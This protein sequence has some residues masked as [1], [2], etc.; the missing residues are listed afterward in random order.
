MEQK[1]ESKLGFKDH[2]IKFYFKNKVKIYL[3][4]LIFISGILTKIF[5]A[6]Y[7]EEKNIAVSEKYVQAEL[8]LSSNKKDDA[9]KI[10]EEI[11]RSKNKFYSI[12]ALNTILEKKLVSEDKEILNLFDLIENISLSKDQADLILIKKALYLKKIN[13][14]NEGKKILQN[15]I[16]KDSQFKL[17]AEEIITK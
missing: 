9:K 3:L 10:L 7:N 6:Y 17:L 1:I 16:D 11:I 14:I 12:L 15:L 8:Y 5:L 4:I 13:K 2:L